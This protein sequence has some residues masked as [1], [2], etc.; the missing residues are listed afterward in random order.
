[1]SVGSRCFRAWR[2]RV[3]VCVDNLVLVTSL[4]PRFP[5]N[6]GGNSKWSFSPYCVRAC[7]G[8]KLDLEL[9]T[10]HIATHSNTVRCSP[11][12]C[13]YSGG[14]EH[15]SILP[16]FRETVKLS[17]RGSRITVTVT[18]EEEELPSIASGER[19]EGKGDREQRLM[20]VIC[21]G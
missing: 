1:M 17:P 8:M 5:S 9:K 3:T 20:V 4:V 19:E 16:E 13:L 11:T 18:G 2:E 7:V 15:R 14:S 10:S 21:G 6:G 12:G